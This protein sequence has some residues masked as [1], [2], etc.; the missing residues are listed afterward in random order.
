MFLSSSSIYWCCIIYPPH[1]Y[2][3]GVALPFPFLT[4]VGVFL[5]NFGRAP[6]CFLL[7]ACSVLLLFSD[8]ARLG[9]LVPFPI[10]DLGAARVLTIFF[11]SRG[12]A[13]VGSFVFCSVT[14]C[15]CGR[16]GFRTGTFFL[17]NALAPP[18]RASAE[19]SF[20]FSSFFE[21]AFFRG[22]RRRLF[23]LL[24]REVGL[25]GPPRGLIGFPFLAEPG[26][27]LSPLRASVLSLIAVRKSK[28]ALCCTVFWCAKAEATLNSEIFCPRSVSPRGFLARLAAWFAR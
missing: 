19:R 1:I 26:P 22:L 4:F 3:G 12:L 16:R 25:F 28:G 8:L 11:L 27:A 7:C 24:G 2:F 5:F 6:I 15:P 21:F 10:R 18:G 23:R 20:F 17:V 13:T 14:P 9:F